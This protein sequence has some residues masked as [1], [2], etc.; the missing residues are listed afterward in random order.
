M[1]CYKIKVDKLNGSSYQEIYPK[2][3]GIFLRIKKRT[4]RKPYVRSLYFRKNKIFLD[5]FWQHL[6]QK[7]WRDRV[8]RL[9]FY[10]CALDLIRY[11]KIDPESKDNPNNFKEIIHRFK[12]I[13]KNKEI[14]FVQ[15]KEDKRTNKKYFISIF[16]EK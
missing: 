9:K 2:A 5:Y 7:N 13:T 12:G 3:K 6:H 1:N 11:S 16:P 14:F 4:K 10:P 15:I 8:R